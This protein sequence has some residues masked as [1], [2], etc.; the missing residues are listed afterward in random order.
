MK[1]SNE[2]LLAETKR[3]SRFRL[4]TIR[5]S[6]KI[7]HYQILCII[8]IFLPV[9]FFTLFLLQIVDLLSLR[10]QTVIVNTILPNNNLL[11]LWIRRKIICKHQNVKLQR[12]KRRQW[13]W[14]SIKSQFSMGFGC[15]SPLQIYEELKNVTSAHRHTYR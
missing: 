6:K 9:F 2:H 3:W 13:T 1:V 4:L 11:W 7:K 15:I 5:I 8:I 12:P 10:A 14:H